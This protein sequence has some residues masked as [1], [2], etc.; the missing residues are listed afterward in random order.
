MLVWRFFFWLIHQLEGTPGI[1]SP[2]KITLRTWDKVY[3][4]HPLN[5]L[6]LVKT[7][8]SLARLC[9]SMCHLIGL[10][11]DKTDNSDTHVLPRIASELADT[12]S[13]YL[14]EL[15]LRTTKHDV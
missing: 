12:Y 5:L 13:Y 7:T 14:N 10:T 6:L 1:V 8:L 4:V 15:W 11:A 2:Q 3:P 9:S